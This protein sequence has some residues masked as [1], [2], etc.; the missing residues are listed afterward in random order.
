MREIT[1][2]D[3]IR[4]ALT[5]EMERQP[6][7][8]IIGEDLLPGG[9]SFGVHLGMGER[10]GARIFESPISEASIVGVALGVAMTGGPAVA[11]IMYSDFMTVCIIVNEY[12]DDD[13][14]SKYTPV[15]NPL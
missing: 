4:E 3:A 11:E 10:F 8:V 13:E 1:F 15:L 7:M 5:E 14:G 2:R 6:G 9:G 12:S